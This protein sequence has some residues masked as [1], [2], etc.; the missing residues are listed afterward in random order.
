MHDDLEPFS[1][2][3]SQNFYN[4]FINFEKLQNFQKKIPKS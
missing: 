4:N 2:T 1:Q 3:I